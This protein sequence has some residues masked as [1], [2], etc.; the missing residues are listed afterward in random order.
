MFRWQCFYT[1]KLKFILAQL[2]KLSLLLM[3]ALRRLQHCTVHVPSDKEIS[4]R[5]RMHRTISSQE[6]NRFIH[7]HV[8]LSSHDLSKWPF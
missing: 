2:Q 6:N 1:R 4:V 5:S 3:K 7:T 8:S